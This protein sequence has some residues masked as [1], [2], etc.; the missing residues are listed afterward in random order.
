MSVG[1]SVSASPAISVPSGVRKARWSG[2][3]PGVASDGQA[4]PSPR[5]TVAPSAISVAGHDSWRRAARSGH[6]RRAG[7]LAGGPPSRRRGPGRHGSARSPRSA[8]RVVATSASIASRNASPGSPGSTTTTSR[9]PTST[10]LAGR[11]SGPNALWPVITRRPGR[12]RSS[13]DRRVRGRGPGRSRIAAN[14]RRPLEP[15]ERGRGRRPHPRSRPPPSPPARPAASARRGPRPRADRAGGPRRVG[16]SA[17]KNRASNRRGHRPRRRPVGRSRRG[18][19]SGA[20]GRAAS[21]SAAKVS[22]GAGSPGRSAGASRRP[23]G[24]QDA[25]LLPGL[26]DRGDPVR[27][28]ERRVVARSARPSDEARVGV[29]GLDAAAREDV[30]ARPRTPSSRGGGSAGP[31]A[32]PGRAGRGRSSRPGAA[33]PGGR[34][35][36]GRAPSGPSPGPARRVGDQGRAR[37]R[38]ARR[39]G[40]GSP[41]RSGARRKPIRR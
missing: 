16:S 21:T 13:A 17:T 10:V 12:I 30:E 41:S 32:R 38:A 20:P 27:D 35:P 22:P 2:R 5:P 31:R 4:V 29:G 24:E 28:A 37:S 25:D 14:D 6:D 15:L 40:S 1:R 18:R 26:A 36:V 7:P 23:V 19:R 33:R 9:R 11:P 8:R 39:P 3:W 34:S